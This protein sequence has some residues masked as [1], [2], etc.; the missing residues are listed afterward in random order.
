MTSTSSHMSSQPYDPLRFCIF[1]TLALLT[2]FL[3]PIVIVVMAALGIWAYA[4]AIRDGLTRT[5]CVLRTP[6][7]AITYLACALV[8]GVVAVGRWAGRI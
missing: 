3:G 2:W 5:K 4:R 7:I 6:K 1:T 8:V